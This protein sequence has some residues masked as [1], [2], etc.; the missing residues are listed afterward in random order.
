MSSERLPRSIRRRVGERARW[1][2]EYCLSPAAFSTHSFEADHVIPRSKGG[3][4]TLA[5]LALSCGCNGYKGQRTHARDPETGRSV[6]LF[7]PRRQLWTRHFAWSADFML[8]LGRTARGRATV[9]ALHLN[10][11]ELVNLRRIL[12]H[13]GEH[14]PQEP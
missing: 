6:A 1:R 3:P 2:C 5:N 10:R 9:D 14:P 7:N 4:T 12:H 13:L 11:P 8:I